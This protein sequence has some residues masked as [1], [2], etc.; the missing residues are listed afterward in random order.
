M[1]EQH[2]K[3]VIERKRFRKGALYYHLLLA[4]CCDWCICYMQ[5]HSGLELASETKATDRE[6]LNQMKM[7][8]RLK[9]I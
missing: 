6:D 9:T 2:V 3:P 4:Y 1:E 7:T 8:T 5:Y